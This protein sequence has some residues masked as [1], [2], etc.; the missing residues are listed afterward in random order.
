MGILNSMRT[1]AGTLHK[2]HVTLRVGA[3]LTALTM[4]SL[5]LATTPLQAQEQSE[6][7]KKTQNPV[8][9]LISLPLQNNFTFDVGPD[10]DLLWVLN[11]QPVIPV[12]AGNW[13]LIHR[14]ILP[15]ID[16]PA[17]V[18]GQDDETGLGDLN[19]QLFVSPAKA[20]KWV[21][22]IG[23]SLVIPT[24]SEDALGTEK[25]SLGPS[26]VALTMPGRWVIGG[27]VTQVWS[28]AG[29]DDREDVSEFLFQYF[30][31]YNFQ[32]GWYVTSAPI[33]TADWEAPSSQR[34]IVPFGGGFGKIARFGKQPVNLSFQIYYNVERPD[35]L[36]DWSARF[37]IQFLFPKKQ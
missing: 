15:L 20:G 35:V 29:D 26:F 12:R 17:L 2:T 25:W 5:M 23:P 34:W 30:I 3:V 28:F 37:Q 18:P 7:A 27:L 33:I 11:V 19:Y 31:N 32:R 22:G 36:G 4:I 10:D 21:W 16:Q 1:V 14:P 9:D 8:S 13:N 24:A 6:L